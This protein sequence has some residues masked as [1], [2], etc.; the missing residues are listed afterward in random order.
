MPGSRL[1]G[2]RTQG[3]DGEGGLVAKGQREG[4]GRGVVW[5]MF[6]IVKASNHLSVSIAPKFQGTEMT[7]I[8]SYFD[9]L[10]LK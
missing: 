7:G 8:Q 3:L 1:R 2:G 5:K 9:S 6:G 4:P 10:L